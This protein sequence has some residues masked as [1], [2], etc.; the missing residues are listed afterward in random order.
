MNY[1]PLFIQEACLLRLR[2]V[3]ADDCRMIWEWANDALVRS[4][5]FASDPIPWESHVAWFKRALRDPDMRL[6]IA[7]SSAPVGLARF[8]SRNGETL[9]SV[10]IAAAYRGRGLG[11]ELTKLAS[12]EMLRNPSVAA[13]H[14][15]IKPENPSSIAM[16]VAAGYERGGEVVREGSRALHFVLRG[17]R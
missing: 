10:T 17:K 16:V 13:I 11:S 9:I 5:S 6:Y 3:C 7:E 12:S 2:P 15:Y 4:Q 8:E 14:A 1:N